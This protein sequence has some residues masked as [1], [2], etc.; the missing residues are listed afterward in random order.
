LCFVLVYFFLV[1]FKPHRSA[2]GRGLVEAL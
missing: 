2:G 1:R